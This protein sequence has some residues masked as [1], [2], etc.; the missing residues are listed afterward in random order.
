[1]PNINIENL[2]SRNHGVRGDSRRRVRENKENVRL[3][4]GVERELN[5]SEFLENKVWLMFEKFIGPDPRN[6]IVNHMSISTEGTKISWGSGSGES[7]QID[8]LFV[9]K[10]IVFVTESFSGSARGI[11]EKIVDFSQWKSA[12]INEARIHRHTHNDPPIKFKIMLRTVV[13]HNK[14]IIIEKIFC[15]QLAP[16]I[17][18]ASSN[19]MFIL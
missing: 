7:Q 8:G 10:S 17:S 1:M 2:V 4:D 11:G 14:G 6:P 18:E 12:L 16:S 5:P 19:S 9:S 3:V 15:D 13:G